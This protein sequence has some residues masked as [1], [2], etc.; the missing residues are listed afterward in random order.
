MHSQSM[1]LLHWFLPSTCTP[2]KVKVAEILE[3]SEGDGRC[4]AYLKLGAGHIVGGGIYLGDDDLIVVGK[5]LAQ[6][7]PSKHSAPQPR[8]TL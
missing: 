6:L 4:C 1:I 5:F 3:Y 7:H 2:Y 8:I